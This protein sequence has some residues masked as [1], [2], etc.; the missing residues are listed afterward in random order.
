MRGCS[1]R[2]GA[3]VMI[4]VG[5]LF[6][7]GGISIGIVGARAAREA[8]ERAAR[9]PLMTAR[10]IERSDIG[11]EVIVEGAIDARNPPRFRNFVAYIREEYRGLDS[12]DDPTWKEDER[13]TPP[14]LIATEDGAVQLAND[15]YR[16]EEPLARWQESEKP[17]WNGF[18]GEGTKRYT[19]FVSDSPA[20]VIGRVVEGVEGHAVEAELMFGGTRSGYIA[21]QQTTASISPVLGMVSGVLGIVILLGGIWFFFRG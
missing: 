5:I 20:L 15:T 12:Q 8:A 2:M 4:L 16:L 1:E 10:D 3:I 7:I 11:T 17:G 18:S 14:L 6:I 19:G 21:F 9:L 13:W